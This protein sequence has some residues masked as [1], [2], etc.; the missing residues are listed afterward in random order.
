MSEWDEMM[1][2]CREDMVET[3]ILLNIKIVRETE[4]AYLIA[5]K[6]GQESWFPKSVVL[7]CDDGEAIEFEQWFGP[8]WSQL[9]KTAMDS[10]EGDF[11]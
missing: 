7:A 9:Q 3:E 10:I 11:E 6:K 2:D 8:N 1:Y 5:N 4:K